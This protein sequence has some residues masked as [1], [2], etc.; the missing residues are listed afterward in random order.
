MIAE[1]EELQKKKILEVKPLAIRNDFNVFDDDSDSDDEETFRV[2]YELIEGEP[3][4][5]SVILM[6]QVKE[7][8]EADGDHEG[9]PPG[10][11]NFCGTWE[12]TE[13]NVSVTDTCPT[14]G[15]GNLAVIVDDVKTARQAVIDELEAWGKE[16]EDERLVIAEVFE[17]NSVESNRR[18]VTV[19]VAI[20]SAAAE[21]VCPL[22]WAPEFAVR[23]C[24]PG[25]HKVGCGGLL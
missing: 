10:L 24:A 21:S 7:D 18:S 23:P 2:G 12:Q 25:D 6:D 22:D 20:D 3:E 19:K 15:L 14:H 16:E 11:V 9:W 17:V 8:S 4:E 13:M 5:D 1:V